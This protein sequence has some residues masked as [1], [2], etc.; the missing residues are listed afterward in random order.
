MLV[1]RFV[2]ELAALLK[3]INAAGPYFIVGILFR[4]FDALDP[5]LVNGAIDAEIQLIRISPGIA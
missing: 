3:I 5:N 1:E 2:D 4:Q